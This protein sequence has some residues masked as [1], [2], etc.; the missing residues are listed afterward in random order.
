MRPR[1]IERA[2][3]KNR[4]RAP[5]FGAALGA[6]VLC[7]WRDW[8]LWRALFQYCGQRPSSP[9]GGI[10]LVCGS[11]PPW[12]DLWIL[13]AANAAFIGTRNVAGRVVSLFVWWRLTLRYLVWRDAWA[14][15]QEFP[16]LARWLAP[17]WQDVPIFL[18]VV[19]CIFW[20][21]GS[22]GRSLFVGAQRLWRL[23]ARS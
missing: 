2:W 20:R 12:V 7:T 6:L 9:S 19:G 4:A 16:Y 15:V 5:I 13:L 11:D 10:D 8:D 17:T 14:G 23:T 21:L 18:I 3:H 22:D 1:W